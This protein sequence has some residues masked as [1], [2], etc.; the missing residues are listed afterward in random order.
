MRTQG[1]T[2]FK[3]TDRGEV[4]RIGRKYGVLA[5]PDDQTTAATIKTALDALAGLGITSDTLAG[6]LRYA[7]DD[8]AG[9]TEYLM[10]ALYPQ[11]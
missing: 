3:L 2:R 7:P 1:T 10:S 5:P 8:P 4:V 11:R 9:Q 6:A